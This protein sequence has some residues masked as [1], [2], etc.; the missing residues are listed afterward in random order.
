M[1]EKGT[2]VATRFGTLHLGDTIKA[3]LYEKDG[4]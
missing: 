4:R 1:F 3:R 2:P